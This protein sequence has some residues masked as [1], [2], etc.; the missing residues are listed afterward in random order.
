MKRFLE[1]VL[2]LTVTML[3][4]G[5]VVVVFREWAYPHLPPSWRWGSGGWGL[6]H[7]RVVLDDDRRISLRGN[8]VVGEDDLLV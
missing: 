2:F 4:V 1:V 3:A 6:P 7:G 8:A 5:L